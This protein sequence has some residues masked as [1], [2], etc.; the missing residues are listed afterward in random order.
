MAQDIFE[1]RTMKF[2]STIA[3]CKNIT[4]AAQL[5]YISQPALS[6]F[7][8]TLEKK[9]GFALFNRVGHTVTPT[10]MGERFLHYAR[11]S[12]RLEENLAREISDFTAQ[13]T[14]R[15]RFA[16]PR[17]R[18]AY[19][20]P[21]LV[22]P[23]IQK[24]PDISLIVLEEHAS[25]LAGLLLDDKVDFALVN[26]DIQ[27]PNIVKHHIRSDKL[28]LAVPATHPKASQYRGSS[29]LLPIV[30]ISEFKDDYFIMQPPSQITRRI[31]DKIFRDAGISPN[32]L[33]TTRSI[34][35]AMNLVAKKCGLCFLAE[36]YLN[37][38]A[39]ADICI[40]QIKNQAAT[41]DTFIAYKKDIYCPQYFEYFIEIA[42][43]FQ[44]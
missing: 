36:P 27:H 41:I 21:L 40:F 13:K 26:W 31:A 44:K 3:A 25:E 34:P 9:L 28:Y 12:G 7:L 18:S 43:R 32:I 23:F 1:N 6:S 35:A 22:P 5:L 14:G 19:L 33:L 4:K 11:E 29:D 16:V 10:Y 8:I 15:L 37:G 42:M 38:E 2:I 24:Y 17:S 39:S 20:L 30:D